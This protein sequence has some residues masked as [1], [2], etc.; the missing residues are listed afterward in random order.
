MYDMSMSSN[1]WGFLT[2]II[3]AVLMTTLWITRRK[4][5]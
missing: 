2:L 4:D 3:L 5:P 1:D